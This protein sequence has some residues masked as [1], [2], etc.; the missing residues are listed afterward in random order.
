MWSVIS[1]YADTLSCGT[2]RWPKLIRGLN[3]S[4]EAVGNTRWP[5]QTQ[6]SIS[7]GS[8]MGVSQQVHETSSVA[9]FSGPVPCLRIQIECE[10]R[11]WARLG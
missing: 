4:H 5:S 10:R 1:L 6:S 3:L 9:H 8:D 11:K 2:H 7:V